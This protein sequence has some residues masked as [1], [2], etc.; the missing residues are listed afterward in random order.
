MTAQ[1][2][3]DGATLRYRFIAGTPAYLSSA[4]SVD[5]V[6]VE[7]S[8]TTSISLRNYESGMTMLSWD[9][10]ERYLVTI[11]TDNVPNAGTADDIYLRFSYISIQ[12]TVLSSD[13]YRLRDYV[14]EFYGEWPGNV[15]DFAYNYGFR[16]GGTVRFM[17]PL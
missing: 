4:T 5:G 12:D 9:R 7:V 10:K 15:D 2:Q 6:L 8:N 13:E 3:L 16:D 17:I 1:V 11:S 14:T